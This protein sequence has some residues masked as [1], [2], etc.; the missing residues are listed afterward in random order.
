M[1]QPEMKHVKLCDKCR[2]SGEIMGATMRIFCPECHG[3]RY[4]SVDPRESLSVRALARELYE[5]RK[6]LSVAVENLNSKPLST[7]PGDA[8][9][10]NNGR[11]AGG[12]NYTGD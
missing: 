12:S 4:R 1:K 5:T 10:V 8:Y 3:N 6:A 11:G 7:G 9:Y 2:G